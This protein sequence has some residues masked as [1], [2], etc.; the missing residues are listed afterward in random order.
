M[1]ASTCDAGASTKCPLITSLLEPLAIALIELV[2]PS[3][4][5]VDIAIEAYDLLGAS[6]NWSEDSEVSPRHRVHEHGQEPSRTPV[7]I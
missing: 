5:V 1:P 2:I 3:A 7:R 4:M 6:L